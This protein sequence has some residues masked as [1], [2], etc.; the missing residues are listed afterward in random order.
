MLRA[1]S[2][3][4]SETRK[5][6]LHRN[7]IIKINIDATAVENGITEQEFKQN[8]LGDLMAGVHVA[9]INEYTGYTAIYL[10]LEERIVREINTGRLLIMRETANGGQIYTNNA[11]T[12]QK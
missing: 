11:Q 7:Y 10:Y 2:F 1:S 8:V 3:R 4:R 5:D 12:K 9:G 6:S